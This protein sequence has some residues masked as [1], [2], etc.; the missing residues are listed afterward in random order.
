MMKRLAMVLAMGGMTAM[1]AIPS[2]AADMSSKSH[3]MSGYISDSRCGAM[4][5]GTGADCVKKCISSGEKPVFVDARKNVW[6]IDNPEAV[7]AA[8]DGKAVKVRM[9][10]DATNKTI[11]VEKIHAAGMSS[12]SM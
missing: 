7:P 1:T 11:H 6:A 12:M 2:M 10:M 3:N 5:M 4:H 8:L 9:T